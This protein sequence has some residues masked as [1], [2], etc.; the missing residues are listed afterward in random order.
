MRCD[1][2]RI[3]QS[4]IETYG[5]RPEYM[6]FSV[7]VEL[8]VSCQKALVRVVSGG[9]ELASQEMPLDKEPEAPPPPPPE[10]AT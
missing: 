5:S 4:N 10:T 8:I 2:T 6:K 7:T 9:V 1:L 3:P